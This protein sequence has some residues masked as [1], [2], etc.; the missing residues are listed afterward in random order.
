MRL[1]L[2]GHCFSAEPT[3]PEPVPSPAPAKAP[4]PAPAKGPT[5][6]PA[7]A[8]TA[9]PTPTPTQPPAL[10]T[11]QAV[12]GEDVCLE[13]EV[14]AEAG[15]VIWH[16]GTERIQPGGH[17]EVLSQGQRQMLVIKGFR[18]DDQGEYR[19]CPA[20]GPPSSGAATFNGESGLWS[21]MQ[22]E[23]GRVDW[24]FLLGVLWPQG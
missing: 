20:R 18:T 2:W 5:P 1:I 8:P 24:V 22:W 9:T 14:A 19:C 7:K 15:E 4:T 10:E 6:T 21:R 3:E 17:F 16:K 13:L 23:W 12:V 11:R